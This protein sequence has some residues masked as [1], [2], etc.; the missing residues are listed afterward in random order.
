[1][2]FLAAVLLLAVACLAHGDD[3]VQKDETIN[4]TNEKAYKLIY[5]A[6]TWDVAKKKCEENGAKLAV[7]KSEEE[8]LFLQKEVVRKMHYPSI[9]GSNYKYLVWLGIDNRNDNFVWRDVDGN[10]IVENGYNVWSGD[11]GKITK[12]SANPA[13]PHCVGMDAANHG[14]RDFWCHLP[15]PYVC[16]TLL[17]KTL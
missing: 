9:I 3:G 6:E 17:D 15:Q 7:P 1:M 16:E 10:N 13:E 14:L 2:K 4:K 11:N 8:F 5:V 12:F